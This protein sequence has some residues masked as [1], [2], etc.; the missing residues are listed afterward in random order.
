MPKTRKPVADYITFEQ[1]QDMLKKEQD[2][3]M[4]LIYRY[5][6]TFL[7]RVSEVVGQSE[8]DVRVI[9]DYQKNRTK[10]LKEIAADPERLK[11]YLERHKG[12]KPIP[13]FKWT[14]PIPGIRPMDI[15][16]VKLKYAKHSINIYRKHGKFETFPFTDEQLFKDTQRI[17]GGYGVKPEE[18]IFPH[19]QYTRQ[20]VLE[21]MQAHGYTVGQQTL[22]HPHSLRRGGGIHLRNNDVKLEVLQKLYSHDDMAQT[23][24]YIGIDTQEAFKEFAL[25]QK[26]VNKPRRGS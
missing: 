5:M 4:Q 24:H 3:R 13:R 7:L 20:R 26:A 15:D 21:A 10:Q 14:G 9:R 22:R 11:E 8:S 17:I 2:P 23:T 16:A 19:P 25:V 12:K 6:W 1:Y 18:R